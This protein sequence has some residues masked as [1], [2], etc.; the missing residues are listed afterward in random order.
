[1]FANEGEGDAGGGH[2]Q[3]HG[4]D[5]DPLQTILQRVGVLTE[6]LA[7]FAQLPLRIALLLLKLGDF[8]LLLRRE[9]L[10]LPRRFLL[11]HLGQL[12]LGGLQVFV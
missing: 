9:K 3:G 1:M 7:H 6:I 11:L 5:V 4:G 2:K 12:L 8:L 10:L